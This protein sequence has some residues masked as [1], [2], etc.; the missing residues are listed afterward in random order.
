M[1]LMHDFNATGQSTNKDSKRHRDTL[2]A[3]M[4]YTNLDMSY[5]VASR[6]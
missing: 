2:I 4:A 1:S 3:I 6:L 5:L